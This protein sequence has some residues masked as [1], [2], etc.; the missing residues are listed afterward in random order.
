MLPGFRFLFA[1]IVL[2]MSI[3]VFGL[4]AAALLRT[5]HEEFASNPTWRAPPE[6]MF[7]QQAEAA[8]PVLAMLQIE[9]QAVAQKAPDDVP[10]VAAAAESAAIIQE[11]SI[12]EAAKSET[13]VVESRAQRD[14]PSAQA[15]APVDDT[16]KIAAPD[17]ETMVAS[18]GQAQPPQISLPANEAALVASEQAAP[19]Q[20]STQAPAEIGAASTKI[21]TLVLPP[22]TIKPSPAV[23][24]KNDEIA[25]KKR[26]QARKAAQR[27]KAAARARLAAQQAQQPIPPAQQQAPQPAQQQAFGPFG[28]PSAQPLAAARR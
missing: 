20:A 28:Q 26:L 2:S 15:N 19:G 7:A 13:P 3:L 6:T 1:A 9:P 10:A 12:P 23:S 11:S 21:A 8:A 25:I 17:A 16:P 18:S 5:A 14:T 27:R 4:G 22:V 24:K